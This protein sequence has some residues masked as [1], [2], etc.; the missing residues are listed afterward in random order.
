MVVA[1]TNVWARAHLNDDAAQAKRA[2]KALADA[3]AEGGVF[4]P[5]LVLAELAWVLRAKWERERV[6]EAIERLLQTRGVIV[7]SPQLVQAA[8]DSTRDGGGGGFSDHLIA[9]V[10]FANGAREVITFDPKF[11][12]AP[13]VR[14]LK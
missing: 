11:G 14:R 2:R 3:Q 9:S 8:L 7:E 13:R 10:G 6:L 4:V 1:D 5:M 12:G